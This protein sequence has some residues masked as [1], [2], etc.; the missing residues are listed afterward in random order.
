MRYNSIVLPPF[1]QR[2]E[3]LRI[4]YHYDFADNDGNASDVNGHGSHVSS[5]AAGIASGANIIHLKVLDDNGSGN[6]FNIERALQWVVANAATYNVASVNLSLGSGNIN[7]F[8]TTSFS[9][10]YAA[11]AAQDIVVSVAS[12]ND[13]SRVNSVQGVNVLSAAPGH[14]PPGQIASLLSPNAT[15]LSLT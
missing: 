7:R 4:V 5:I 15:K 8:V 1:F 10:E 2:H 6:G 9:N 11:L 13:F 12:G 14:S 3:T